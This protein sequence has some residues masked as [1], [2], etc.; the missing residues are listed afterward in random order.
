MFRTL[1][2]DCKW[3]RLPQTFP[4]SEGSYSM[5]RDGQFLPRFDEFGH[6]GL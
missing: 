6:D 1:V 4:D 5:G 2:N 3:L